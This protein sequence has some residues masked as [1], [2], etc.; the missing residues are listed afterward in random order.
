[1]VVQRVVLRSE[2]EHA[3]FDG[4]EQGEAGQ[5]WDERSDLLEVLD[6]ICVVGGVHLFGLYDDL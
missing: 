6:G 5:T 4:E 3:G 1:M 2:R